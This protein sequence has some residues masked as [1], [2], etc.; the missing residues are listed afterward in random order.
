[1]KEAVKKAAGSS[2]IMTINKNIAANVD[3]LVQKYIQ[4]AMKQGVD[5][6]TLSQEQLKMIVA[7]NRPQPPR[8]YSGDE[9]I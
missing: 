9:A 1:M 8:I 4:D 5:L 6:E 7:M 2:G 3:K